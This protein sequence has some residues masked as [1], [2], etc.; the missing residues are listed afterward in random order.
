LTAGIVALGL[1][2]YTRLRTNI[3]TPFFC[4]IELRQL[5]ASGGIL[6]AKQALRQATNFGEIF[7]QERVVRFSPRFIFI[8]YYA[9]VG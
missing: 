8:P 7:D 4:G 9:T 2:T 3:P 6:D 5:A 1:A